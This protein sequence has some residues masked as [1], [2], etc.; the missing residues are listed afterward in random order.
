M[1]TLQSKTTVKSFMMRR[2]MPSTT[3]AS[4]QQS[5]MDPRYPPASLHQPMVFCQTARKQWKNPLANTSSKIDK[6]N[7]VILTERPASSEILWKPLWQLVVSQNTG[8]H[9]KSQP[10][11]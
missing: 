2:A 11:E 4:P 7:R 9:R 1:P 6:I 5:T 3:F 10:N 8:A